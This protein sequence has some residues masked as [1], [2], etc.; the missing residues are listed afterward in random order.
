MT[1]PDRDRELTEMFV[2]ETEN[3][4]RSLGD[5]VMRN[6]GAE[7][8]SEK[9]TNELFRI[10][11]TIKGS[12]AM[13][14][15]DSLS[16]AA[17][18][19][20][21]LFSLIRSG[22]ANTGAAAMKLIEDAL[23]SA[24]K[25]FHSA[26]EALAKDEQPPEPPAEV[27]MCTEAAVAALKGESGAQRAVVAAPPEAAAEP[28]L[29]DAITARVTL[30]P[31][32][33]PAARAIVVI[34][35]A[36]RLCEKISSVPP[37][38]ELHPELAERIAKEGFI[39]AFIPKEGVKP[40]AVVAL[41]KKN[42][43]AVSCSIEA[44][45]TAVGK[46]EDEDRIVSVRQSKLTRHLDLLE[47]LL[48]TSSLLETRLGAAGRDAETGRL[49]L[50]LRDCATEL[51]RSAESM[52]MVTVEGLFFRLRLILRDMCARLGK[53]A[54]LVCSGGG[55]EVGRNMLDQLYDPLLHLVRNAL[56]HGV[57]TK[58]RRAQAGK[59]ERGVVRIDVSKPHDD[60]LRVEVSDDGAGID[61]DAVFARA[62]QTGLVSGERN[63]LTDQEI[64]SLLLR[65]GFTTKSKVS[66]YSGRG[67]GLDVVSTRV[68]KLG[69]VLTVTSEPGVGSTF[70]MTL[71]TQLSLVDALEVVVCGRSLL[72]PLCSVSKI[73]SQKEFEAEAV[74]QDDG[75]LLFEG[76]RYFPSDLPGFFG[77]QAAADGCV[78]LCCGEEQS[79]VRVDD[80][81]HIHTAAI[82]PL[83]KLL[84]DMKLMKQL[85]A[86]CAVLEEGS[87]SMALNT[88]KLHSIT[89]RQAPAQL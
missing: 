47:E 36:A 82:K 26:T 39:L 73:L 19:L 25:Y 58:E 72:V 80:V 76:V 81:L 43:H 28:W 37:N 68:R 29:K 75:T 40:E 15:L 3:M 45:E 83:P 21:D 60:S 22:Q 71:P 77:G 38:L 5:A 2:Y 55:T 87:V 49:L 9:D 41:V 6:E 89:E 51:H 52:N 54:A 70:V 79:A 17:H 67:V 88:D 66:E 12:A 24:I 34:K 18:R 35:S 65:P 30:K 7:T 64:Y 14:Q 85:Y 1:G 57:E 32:P 13:L 23:L 11:H 63:S 44:Q 31:S 53:D 50:R 16:A 33:L 61:T 20:E 27:G 62:E 56:D 84:Q 74:A 78:L 59:P 48:T 8:L 42:I 46:K 10:M 86:G 4:L 69:G